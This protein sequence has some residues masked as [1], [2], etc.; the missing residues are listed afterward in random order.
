MPPDGGVGGLI[1]LVDDR[2]HEAFDL[3]GLVDEHLRR[4]ERCSPPAALIGEPPQT[5]GR[6]EDHIRVVTLLVDGA[7]LVLLL[8]DH[9]NE[10]EV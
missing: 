9:A 7:P 5:R 3:A 10:I 4:E 2:A 8:G 6:L 1:R